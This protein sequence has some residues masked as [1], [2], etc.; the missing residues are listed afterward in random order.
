ML[1]LA[2]YVGVEDR[3]QSLISSGEMLR[4]AQISMSNTRIVE[5]DGHKC[6]VVDTTFLQP[7]D[8]EYFKY[9]S[10]CDVDGNLI[11]KD[12]KTADKKKHNG[13]HCAECGNFNEYAE[14]NRPDGKHI[15]YSCRES[16]RWKYKT[17]AAC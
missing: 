16:Y 15:C 10:P 2:S 5:R 6:C 17:A 9:C 1:V 8:V 11:G 13:C 4:A 14:P 3:Y 12:D 7:I